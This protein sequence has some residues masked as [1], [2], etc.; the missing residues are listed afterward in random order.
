MNKLD[1]L[2]IALEAAK[3]KQEA[4]EKNLSTINQEKVA[5]VEKFLNPYFEDA[6]M[7]DDKL[8]ISMSSY[9]NAPTAYIKRPHDDYSYLK[10][11]VTVRFRVEYGENEISKVET[12]FYSTTDDS[13]YE[14]NRMVTIG[15]VGTMLLDFGDDMIAGLNSL[16]KDFAGKLAEVKKEYY[17]ARGAVRDVNNMIGQ[18]KKDNLFSKLEKEG[19]EFDTTG[20]NSP[21]FEV[22]FNWTIYNVKK[23]QLLGKTASGK[24]AKVAITKVQEMWNSETESYDKKDQ[25]YEETVRMDKLEMFLASNKSKMLA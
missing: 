13:I 4:A 14:L 7:K 23:V 6:M 8:E 9:D 11:M 10:E 3:Q 25:L 22:K 21:A 16:N 2:E 5:A 18:I 19:I 1:V 24:S 17:E 20:Y 15:Q 12:G